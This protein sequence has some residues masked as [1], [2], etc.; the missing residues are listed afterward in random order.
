MFESLVAA[1]AGTS[2]AGGVRAWTCVENAACAR[3]LAASADVLAARWS[4]DGSAERDQWCLDNWDAVAAEVAAAQNVSHGVASHQLLVAMALR[5]RL[6]RVA[7]VFASG[8]ISY[9][10]VTTIVSRTRLVRDPDARTQLDAAI[11]AEVAGWSDLSVAKAEAAIDRWV[12]RIDPGALRRTQ[13]NSRGRHL[14]IVPNNDGSGL[15]SVQGMLYGH[16]GAA[17]NQRLLNMARG[18]CDKDPRTVDQRRSDAMG[19]LAIGADRL[20]CECGD[21]EC[22]ATANSA[23]SG[24]VIHVIAEER[25]LADD[26]PVQLDGETPPTF[27]ADKPLREK[28]IAEVS[29]PEP[30]TGPAH[31]NPALVIGGGIM[32]APLLAAKVA[33]AATIRP[34][35]HPG[36]APP[37]PRYVPSRKLADFVRCRDLTCRFPGC[38]EPAY[39]CDLDHTIPYP[40]GPTC[41]SNLGC[42]CRKHHLLKTYWGWSAQQSPDGTFIWRAPSGQAYT[43]YPGSRLHF[44]T[45][46]KPTAPVAGPVRSPRVASGLMMPRRKHTRDYHRQRSIEAE[47]KLNDDRIA[48]RNKPPPF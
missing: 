48:E 40:I 22:S 43:T 9:R 4:A 1:A 21:P 25:S 34:L 37:E 17:L 33:N 14:D 38:D 16:Y 15:D 41:A 2:G 20:A 19:A 8:T 3:R 28:T 39:R 13:T 44:P 24:P 11:A 26:T 31:T 32:P 46:C 23:P 47:R 6:P 18:L 10:L 7:E 36:D 30:Q 12:D 45:L 27:G 42:L 5:E 29:A 35:I